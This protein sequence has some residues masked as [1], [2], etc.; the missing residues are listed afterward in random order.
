LSLL[1]IDIGTTG[2]KVGAFTEDG[3][4]LINA[5]REYPVLVNGY[6]AEL[7]P[8]E[9]W[10]SVVSC[11]KQAA[12]NIKND[13]VRAISVSAMGDTFTAI[14][15]SGEC[16]GNSIVSFD[17][18]AYE[19]ARY[20]EEKLGKKRIFEIT[21]Q[22]IHTSYTGCKILWLN[23]NKPEVAEKVWKY[24]CYE[25]YILWR[26]GAEPHISYSM[27]GRTL[28]IN[29]K[30]AAW[31]KELLDICGVDPSMLAKP[32]P[33]GIEVGTIS[34]S[35][36]KKLGLSK[37]VRLISGAFDQ[38]CC[39]AGC[40][41]LDESE[42]V[43]TTGTNEIF[44]FINNGKNRD[45]A[46]DAN[47][48]YSFHA[49]EG[50]YASFAQIFNAG[51][52]FRWYRDK[53][54]QKEKE[55]AGEDLYHLMD[56]SMPG[57][58]TGIYFF[59]HLSGIGTP[60]MDYSAKGAIYG[61]MLDTDRH[62]IAKAILEGATY[63][64][65]INLGIIEKII[66]RHIEILKAVG[67]AAKSSVW[68]QLK[69]DITGRNIEVYKGLEPGTA[70]AAVLAGKGCGVFSSL[71]EGSDVLLKHFKKSVYEPNGI[72]RIQY[73]NEYNNYLKIREKLMNVLSQK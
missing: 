11:I 38:A 53:Y 20:I 50:K 47:M 25:E 4:N 58:A 71:K 61:L 36:A 13:P 64:L 63:E 70:G 73:V 17:T 10:K 41:V 9:V 5:Y 12:Q 14:S 21:G 35:M 19:E 39:A 28:L 37:K 2:C 27:A 59:P 45:L 44:Y 66:E 68:I 42:G 15:K 7:N 49:E 72:K 29:N 33:S 48:S 24:L 6:F 54:F 3:K 55:I 67:G 56:S 23:R 60:E 69:A 43:D 30:T 52:A 1:G 46:L 40:G 51:G 16:I 22:P 26:L 57:E 62:R 31:D 32:C 8:K 65:N 18:R 34:T